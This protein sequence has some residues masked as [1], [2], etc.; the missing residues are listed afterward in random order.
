MGNNKKKSKQPQKQSVPVQEFVNAFTEAFTPLLLELLEGVLNCQKDDSPFVNK[1]L[2]SHIP[3]GNRVK[4]NVHTKKFLEKCDNFSSAGVTGI[5][6]IARHKARQQLDHLSSHYQ[7]SFALLAQNSHTNAQQSTS[8][9]SKAHVLI[10]ER[11]NLTINNSMHIDSTADPSVAEVHL[12]QE[13]D[14]NNQQNTP[15]TSNTIGDNI[16]PVI[17]QPEPKS[18]NSK[19]VRLT[20]NNNVIHDAQQGQVCTIMIYDIPTAR[21][22]EQ[23]LELL[24]EWGRV[25]E[26]SF[27]TQHK[28]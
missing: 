4:P 26:I 28:F 13:G 7:N 23:I 9:Q 25:L 22:H 15:S 14:L 19:I 17:T 8:S 20:M 2:K 18:K 11:A 24:K 10:G 27:K 5:I 6:S 3:E 21:S 12:N 16:P 1:L